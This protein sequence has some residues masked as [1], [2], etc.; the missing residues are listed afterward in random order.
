MKKTVLAVSAVLCL[1]ASAAFAGPKS[2]KDVEGGS[3]SDGRAFARKMVT[4][5]NRAEDRELL[6][7]EG[8]KKWCLKDESYCS[9][10]VIKAAKKACKQK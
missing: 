8:T 5:T 3:A 7:F 4:C 10:D 6:N 9:R 1:S 2:F